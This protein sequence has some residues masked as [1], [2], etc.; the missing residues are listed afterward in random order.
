MYNKQQSAYVVGT[1]TVW[2]WNNR[3][4]ANGLHVSALHCKPM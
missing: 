4:C 3:P 1:D 2:P